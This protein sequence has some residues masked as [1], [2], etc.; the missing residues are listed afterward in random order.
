[1]AAKPRHLNSGD[2]AKCNEI[3]ARYHCEAEIRDWFKA[4]QKKN[5]DA[6]ISSAGR[7]KADQELYFT[8]G[9]SKAHW[10]QSAHNY[11]AAVDIFQIGSDGK[12]AW[13]RG[14]FDTVVFPA[15]TTALKWYGAKGSPFFEL[16]H[17]ELADWKSRGLKLVE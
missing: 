14:W 3:F 16:P 4:L 7:G 1:M 12:A 17:V 5:P 10:G 8:Q 13:P 6:H 11:G 2:C 15:L 9:T